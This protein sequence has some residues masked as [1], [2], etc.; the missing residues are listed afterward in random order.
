MDA[1]LHTEFSSDPG[2]S[3]GDVETAVRALNGIDRTLV[4]IELDTGATLTVGG[5]PQEFVAEV[6]VSDTERWAVVDPTRDEQPID[7]VVGGQ[8]VDYPARLCISRENALEAARVFMTEHGFRSSRL[9][10]SV[11]S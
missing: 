10:W 3:L 8:S 6:S 4:T 5:G 9:R 11:E 1:T 2:C 7:L